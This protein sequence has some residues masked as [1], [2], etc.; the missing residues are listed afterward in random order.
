MRKCP[1]CGFVDPVKSATDAEYEARRKPR[2]RSAYMRRY[3]KG[4]KRTPTGPGETR[5]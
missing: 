3:R 4:K 1:R 2:D 5:S